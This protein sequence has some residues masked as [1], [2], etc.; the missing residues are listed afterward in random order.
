MDLIPA[1]AQSN[2]VDHWETIIYASDTWS[3]FP[4]ATNPGTQWKDMNFDD[5]SWPQGP[6]G[7]GFE[8]GDDN[9]VIS[10]APSLFMRIKFT[11]QD[12]SKISS[13]L[14]HIDYDDGFI[15]YINGTEIARAG[16]N[17]NPPAYDAYA[18]NHEAEGIPRGYSVDKSVLLNGQNILAIEVHN[19]SAT[20]SDMSS[21]PYLSVGI[22]D[23]SRDYRDTPSW[24]VAPFSFSESNLPIFIMET[25]NNTQIID[26]PKTK[27]HLKI[28]N[29]DSGLNQVSDTA[30]DYDGIIGIEL[31][32]AYSQSLPQ[33]PYGFETRDLLGENNNVSLLGMPQE[34]DWILLA[35]YNEKTFVRNPI[36]FYL[37]NKM[38]HYAPRSCLCEVMLN[39]SYDGIYLFTE[40]IKRDK[41]RVNISKLDADDNLGDSLTGGYIFKID[42][43]S[44]TDSWLGSYSPVDYV[45]AEVHYVYYDPKPD[46]LTTQQK[47][48]IQSYINTFETVLY[49]NS[50]NDY[51]NGY[52]KYLDVPSFVDYFIIGELSRNVDAYKK[53]R[54]FY[55]DNIKKGGLIHSG[56]VWDFDWAWMY[57]VDGCPHFGATDGSG[58]AYRIDECNPWPSPSGWE[59]RLMQDE[60]FVKQVY[61]RYFELRKTIL[62]NEF[63]HHYIDSIADL[64]S[65]AQVR[66]YQRWDILGRDVG[67]PEYP[68]IPATYSGE[69]QRLKEWID[70]RLT[71]LDA[72][73]PGK[74][75]VLPTVDLTSSSQ[76]IVRVFPNPATDY[77]FIESEVF[78]QSVEIFN[79]NGV[80]CKMLYFN[81]LPPHHM[82]LSGFDPGLYLIKITYGD[83]SVKT[84]KLIIHKD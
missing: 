80:S 49:S 74:N 38:G 52:R 39:G 8:D 75:I 16:I 23:T 51:T 50:F 65:E 29:N 2:P 7:I 32:G 26:E 4:G 15:A 20:S 58:W 45:G 47:N 48:Y 43:Y 78:I 66:H 64:V 83:S 10:W 53:S 13:V 81:S 71:W 70:Q 60:R 73:M 59:V 77:F 21:I 76:H 33:K 24:F 40:K 12:L 61:D 63:L 11:V 9:T 31:R 84:E 46:E 28:I 36:S 30:T 27:A 62:S 5:N 34:N 56:P 18:S 14:F 35:N 41:N 22:S 82:D 19:T 79:T 54:Y 1:V 57:L 68:P 42:Y 69:I 37:Y 25:E 72:N 17:G 44:N 6:G 3:Y 55:K 67:A